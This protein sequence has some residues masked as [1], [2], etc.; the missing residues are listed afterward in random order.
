MLLCS[1]DVT[2]AGTCL[3]IERSAAIK[4]RVRELVQML[5]L[6]DFAFNL[7]ARNNNVSSDGVSNHQ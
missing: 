3:E 5:H 6:V 1:R 2:F 4:K 7:A